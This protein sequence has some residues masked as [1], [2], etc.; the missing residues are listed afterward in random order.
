MKKAVL[1]QGKK[2]SKLFSLWTKPSFPSFQ[3]S[4]VTYLT[5]NNLC[6]SYPTCSEET[7]I[8]AQKSQ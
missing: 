7:K 5:L 2:G 6:I 4:C 1:T 3:F 8:E